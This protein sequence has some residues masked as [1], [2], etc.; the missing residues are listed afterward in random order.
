[1]TDYAKTGFS[2][3]FLIDGGARPD[4]APAYQG[5]MKAGGVSKSWGDLTSI[6][7]P[8]EVRYDGFVE[9]DTIKGAEER[10]TMDLMGRYLADVASELLRIG[11]LGCGVDVQV[12]IGKC[13]DPTDF[14]TFTKALVLEGA[15]ISD[16]STDD[17]G[18]IESGERSP[19][20][21]T[22]SI[23]SKDL[24]EI[25][26]LV[27]T[28]VAASVVTNEVVDVTICDQVACGECDEDSSGCQHIYAITL[29]EGGSPGTPPDIVFT[30][31]GSTWYADDI[32]SLGAAEDPSA[33]DC[34]GD[35]IVVVSNDSGSAHY[36]LK[37][38]V[39]AVIDE[40][41]TEIATGFVGA[42]NDCHRATGGRYLYIVGDGGYIYRTDDITAGVSVLDA[43]VA[44]DQNLNRVFAFS[45]EFVVAVGE[46]S[47]VVYTEDGLGWSAVGG[48]GA[49]LSL[50]AVAVQS[51]TTWF[52]G[53]GTGYLYYTVD[54]A[55]NWIAK[56]FPG[57]GAGVVHD[58][59]FANDSVGYLAHATAK[60]AGRI[61]RTYDGGY[62]WNILPEGAGTI[63]DNDRINRVAP[64][65]Y[66]ANFVVGVGLSDLSADGIIVVGQD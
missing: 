14:N 52:V 59:A 18:A 38:E 15:Y 27:L 39:D 63:P 60:P 31:N 35:Y 37:S 21:E 22:G 23:S 49:G 13:T 42:P 17:L 26:R 46:N 50:T 16:W 58:I 32:D 2:R 8:S 62:S 44:T 5:C 36:A 4:H 29:Q 61:L 11:N 9:V 64:C 56:G 12:H 47:A 65:V 55:A 7:C 33:I 1:M 34:V 25:L 51:E 10:A 6:E 28:E 40:T 24:Y 20:N 41:W 53:T 19:V 66:D 48:P 54:K 30:V 3:V 43:G 57:S 45:D